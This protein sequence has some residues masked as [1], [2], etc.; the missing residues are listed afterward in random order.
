MEE[1][2]VFD[3]ITEHKLCILVL[4]FYLYEKMKCPYSFGYSELGFILFACY[5]RM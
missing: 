2:W 1:T 4:D 3:V 5:T